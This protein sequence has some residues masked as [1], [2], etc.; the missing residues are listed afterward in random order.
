ME[1]RITDINKLVLVLAAEGM[2]PMLSDDL[3]QC[4]GYKKRPK[5]GN[6]WSKLFPK[7]F[8]LEDFITKEILTMA[9]IDILNGIKKTIET[10][11]EKLL[12]SVG[13]VDKFLFAGKGMFSH[14]S[15][16]ENLFLTYASYLESDKSKLYEPVILKAK[17]ILDEK[18]CAKF[19][20]GTINLLSVGHFEDFLLKSD[21]IKEVIEK[22]SS[23]NKL[24]LSMPYEI[25][26]KY[27]LLL[28]NKI[29]KS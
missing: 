10:S 3:W 12:I 1:N 14:E 4:Y 9:L 5:K 28:D 13:V 23:E 29:L 8:K 16:M 22:S 17:N 18:D 2:K 27:M 26:E 11:D 15:F 7:M 6:M 21:Y 25:I 24:K 20:V 19:M